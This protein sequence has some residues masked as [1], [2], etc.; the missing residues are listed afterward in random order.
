M[1]RSFASRVSHPR[2]KWVV[3]LCW[4]VLAAVSAPLAGALTGEQENDVAAWL[5]ADAES[6][7]ALQLQTELGSDP[8]VLPAVVVYER[9]AGLTP[10]DTAA[11]QADVG[12]LGELDALAGPLVGP[13]PAQDGQAAQLVVPLDVGSGGWE[14]IAPLVEDV[15]A[16]VSDG[17]EGLDAYVTG[18]AGSAADSA[19]A[20]EGIDGTLLFAALGV[21]V[22]ILLFT[23][24]SPVLWILPIFSAVIALSCSQALIY[25]LARHADLT[26]NAQS[27]SILTVLVVGAGTDYALLLIARYR[28]ELRLHTDRHE[29][30]TEAVHRAGPAVLAS[31]GTVVLGMLCLVVAEMNSTAGLGPVAAI[32]VAVTLAVLMTLLPALLVICGR[33]V[34]W[35]VRPT[36]GSA[37]PTATGL[38]SR[39]G[40]RI[41]PRPRATWLVTS[42]LLLVACAGTLLLSPDGLTQAESFRGTPESIQGGE[43][44]SRHFPAVA[45][46]D[47]HVITAAGSAAEVAD[48]TA[49]TEGIAQVAEP[50]VVGD[51]ALVEAAL[52][53]P[54]DSQAAYDTIERLR[55]ALDDAGDG[56]ALVGG[57]TALNLDVQDAA[58][59]DNLVIIPLI[60]LVVL[61]VLGVL[62]RALVA[63]VLL[64]ATVVLSYG[65][66]L[67]LSAVLFDWTIGVTATDSSF[68][69]FVFV[70]LVALGIDYNIFLMTRVR[71]EAVDHGTR[72]AALIGLAATGGVIT[73][74][75]LVLAA[76]F[77][78]LGTLPLT[79]LTQLGI[80]V[81]LGVLL[82]TIVVRSVLVTALTLDVG[83]H[84]WWPGA[85][86]QRPDE[87]DVPAAGTTA[88]PAVPGTPSRA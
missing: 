37:E 28:E 76:T 39:V 55:T 4:V 25:L 36:F 7:R 88:V 24:R 42:G 15:R 75:G 53:D 54:F 66:A 16:V 32:G 8:D 70:F 52:A 18:P 80:A 40:A 87:P 3:L 38:W 57:N 23:Y 85:L 74:A 47:V 46:N 86:A 9:T 77:S 11:I 21:V 29:A 17:P 79:F 81:A 50:Q 2:L 64:I 78:V 73:S 51:R 34:F 48:A 68:P 19:A 22:L 84:M 65:A 33:W 69:L 31:G 71:E 62:L 35:P 5:P 14:A 45:G 63:P 56:D 83:R 61:L 67:G 1:G 44:A 12:V 13:V 43:V 49:A 10:A 58:Q 27:A 59:R 6:T 82:D 72:R 26:V 41:R 60:M 20:F 30:M